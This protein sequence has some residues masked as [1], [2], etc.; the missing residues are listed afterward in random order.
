MLSKQCARCGKTKIIIKHDYICKQCRIDT[1]S[2]LDKECVIKRKKIVVHHYSNGANA[3]F[4][5]GETRFELLK[6]DHINGDGV[7][8][9]NKGEPSGNVLFRVLIKKGFPK[10]YQI[11]CRKCDTR[12]GNMSHTALMNLLILRVRKIMRLLLRSMYDGIQSHEV[13]Q[14]KITEMSE[15]QMR[16]NKLLLYRY[17]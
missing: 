1:C 17:K 14:R 11:L 2:L 9:R 10:G 5:C 3:C 7:K 4:Y 6:T 15:R 8:G 13:V 16:L 12:K